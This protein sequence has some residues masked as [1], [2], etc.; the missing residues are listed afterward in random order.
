MLISQG[1]GP[2]GP[3]LH[4]APPC[5]AGALA[6]K[7]AAYDF[8]PCQFQVRTLIWLAGCALV[9]RLACVYRPRHDARQPMAC[10]S[11]EPSALGSPSVQLF[12]RGKGKGGMWY[13]PTFQASAGPCVWH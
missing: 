8:F 5:Y 12:Y 4:H 1:R 7:N 3:A 6:G 2:Y 11:I 13:D 9:P 10:A